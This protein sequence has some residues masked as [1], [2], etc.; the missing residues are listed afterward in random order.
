MI[1]WNK[2]FEIRDIRNGEWYWVQKDVLASKDINASD[3]L[4]YSALAYFVNNKTQT[5]FPSYPTIANLTSLSQRTVYSSIKKLIKFKFIS[6]RQKEGRV[7][8][9][10]LLKVP[11]L[12]NFARGKKTHANGDITLAKEHGVPMQN[13]TANNTYFNNT[14]NNSENFKKERERVQ[15]IREELS[16]KLPNF[17]GTL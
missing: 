13:S 4:V 3:K 16:R 9:Y 14:Y 8:Y 5:S 1:D 17:L 2:P 11:T 6:T 7:N 10:E 15:F 12:A